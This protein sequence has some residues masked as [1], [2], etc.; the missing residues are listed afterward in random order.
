[1]Q[2]SDLFG[3]LK[4]PRRAIL[5]ILLSCLTLYF[6][7]SYELID[8]SIISKHANL[9]LIVLSIIMTSMIFSEILDY[10]I[11]TINH[12]LKRREVSRRRA[13][14]KAVL[15]AERSE[16]RSRALKRLNHLSN[17]EV[18]LVAKALAANSPSFT[19]WVNCPHASLLM[20]KKLVFSPVG[21][22]PADHYPFMFYDFAWEELLR[23]KDEFIERDREIKE[24]E[25]KHI[26][27]NRRPR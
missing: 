5:G 2:I 12:N 27:S 11:S 21:Q 18:A 19:W 6:L 26:R 3:I 10:I 4:L 22:H 24:K 25:A 1:M 23:R 13:I 20:S 15:E 8:L 7:N 16:E 9:A 14:K 17:E